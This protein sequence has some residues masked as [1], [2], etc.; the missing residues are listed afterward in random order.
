MKVKETRGRKSKYGKIELKKGQ[1]VTLNPEKGLQVS[2][3]NRAKKRG[4]KLRTW[5]DEGQLVVLRVK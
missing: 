4:W 5:H 1:V 3:I 2:L